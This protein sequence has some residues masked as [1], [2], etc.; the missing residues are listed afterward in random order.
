MSCGKTKVE[1][2]GTECKS[3]S[4]E[5][6]QGTSPY[7]YY[8]SYFPDEVWSRNIDIAR[9]VA[10]DGTPIYT[11]AIVA[12]EDIETGVVTYGGYVNVY[13][14][15][16]KLEFKG[17]YSFVGFLGKITLNKKLLF[18]LEAKQVYKKYEV[19]RSS[20]NEGDGE[21]Y[22]AVTQ[23]N[24]FYFYD[25]FSP[26]VANDH[27]LYGDDNFDTKCISDIPDNS[28]ITVIL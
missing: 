24:S 28:K 27:N 11:N 15:R 17:R 20:T 26:W 19:E 1:F 18:N 9:Y 3:I 5:M 8:Q 10:S 16:E 7:F 2:T 6:Q 25:S 22:A 12:Y 4:I 23:G 14:S 13:S 21:A